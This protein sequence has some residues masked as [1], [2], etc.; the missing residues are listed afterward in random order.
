MYI[1]LYLQ[2]YQFKMHSVSSNEIYNSMDSLNLIP[3][4]LEIKE[5]NLSKLTN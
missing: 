1:L 3:A 2:Y 4:S 5:S